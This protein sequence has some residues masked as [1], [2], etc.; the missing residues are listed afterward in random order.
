MT[1]R[2]HIHFYNVCQTLKNVLQTSRNSYVL[3]IALGNWVPYEDFFS[4]NRS[5]I[6]PV[7]HGSW[8]VPEFPR[9]K[10]MIDYCAFTN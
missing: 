3:I 8:V 5:L 10:R 6:I 2:C 7:V 9:R 1:K 4:K